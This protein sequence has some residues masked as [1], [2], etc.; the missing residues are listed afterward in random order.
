MSPY[1]KSI[2]QNTILVVEK[3]V[4][5]FSLWRFTHLNQPQTWVRSKQRCKGSREFFAVLSK[6]EYFYWI[7]F[8]GNNEHKGIICTLK[9]VGYS[10][11]QCKCLK[12][13]GS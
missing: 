9:Y 11:P 13:S 4:P 3:L 7:I 8:S 6:A 2:T 1:D 10:N 5:E 12:I